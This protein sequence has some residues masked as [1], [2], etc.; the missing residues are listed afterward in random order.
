MLDKRT[1]FAEAAEMTRRALFAMATAVAV[2]A[3]QKPIFFAPREQPGH[4]AGV[5]PARMPNRRIA[6]VLIA[7]IA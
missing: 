7:L 5:G 1:G 6:L 3:Q 4:D 2:Q